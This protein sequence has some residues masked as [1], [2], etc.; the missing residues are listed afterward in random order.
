LRDIF[1]AVSA[2]A[3]DVS[4]RRGEEVRRGRAFIQPVSAVSPEREKSLTPAG[5]REVRRYLIIAEPGLLDG[6]S[7][8][9]GAVVEYPGR[10]F[11]LLRCEQMGSGS[12]WE[13]LLRP[14]GGCG[15]A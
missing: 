7:F 6:S 5:R 11:E 10:R 3:R 15:D 2:F 1:G 12:H 8:G 13:G 4:V 14:L 9:A